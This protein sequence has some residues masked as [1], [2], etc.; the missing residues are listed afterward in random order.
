M[1]TVSDTNGCFRR[2]TILIQNPSF[3]I[4][5]PDYTT[6]LGTPVNITPV[7][8]P[9]SPAYIYSW[10]SPTVSNLSATN[11][12]N[13]VFT[14]ASIGVEQFIVRV[15][16]GICIRQDTINITTLP[17]TF[18]SRD[19]GVCQG[20]TFVPTV[21][22]DPAFTY[23]WSPTTSVSN[24]T[25]INPTLTGDTTRTYTITASYPTC[26]DIVNNLTVTVEPNPVVD[27]GPDQSKC[28]Y[29][30]LFLNANVTPTWFTNYSYQWT[31]PTYVKNPNAP[32]TIYF[33]TTS[34][35]LTFTVTTPLGCTG[36]DNM[37]VE[38]YSGDFGT[39]TPVDTAV[40][41]RNAFTMKAGGGV[42][43]LWEPALYLS[44]ATDS[45]V[46]VTP[47]TSQNYTLYVTDVK[48]CVDTLHTSIHVNP[49]ALVSLPDSATIYPDES[50]QMDPGGNALYFTWFP[51]LGLS[52]AN[53][54]NPVAA[55]PVNT[56]YY[57]TGVTESGCM[58]S[59]SIDVYVS[60]ES[61]LDVPNAFTPGSA[62]NDMLK[63][64]RRGAAT[65]KYFRVYNRWGTKVFETADINK[66]WD[67]TI[68]GVAQPMGVYVYSVEAVTKKGTVFTKQGNVT[69]LR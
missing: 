7:I 65:L 47:L 15:D 52:A 9:Q 5:T 2:D 13:P 36:S 12:L 42:S 64:V 67:G 46:V 41:P 23:T 49:D 28:K 50:Y 40:C 20:V 18:I 56:R 4:N 53:I 45:E 3:T 32:N 11:I 37:F 22:G 35:T 51:P 27:L 63:V 57:L 8:N 60:T 6:C 21:A 30:D 25:I 16:S 33:G 1:V 54:A 66:G 44:S 62:P 43:Y 24:P 69:L 68:N 61:L 55:P 59:D 17:N 48:G 14:P 31:P 34:E 38:V 10:T 26:P 39:V 19:T 29:I 58:A